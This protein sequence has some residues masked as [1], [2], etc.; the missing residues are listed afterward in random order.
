MTRATCKDC[1]HFKRGYRLQGMKV[2]DFCNRHF[3]SIR[4]GDLCCAQIEYPPSED[5]QEL[6]IRGFYEDGSPY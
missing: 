3:H 5:E 4:S 6:G 2:P 1:R